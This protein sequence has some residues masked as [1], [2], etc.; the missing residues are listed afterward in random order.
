MIRDPAL[1][2][3]IIALLPFAPLAFRRAFIS[4][5]RAHDSAVSPY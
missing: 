5:F 1:A 2:K 3:H 4:S